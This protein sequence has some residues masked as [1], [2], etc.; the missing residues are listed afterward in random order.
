MSDNTGASSEPARSSR[1]PAARE[2]QVPFRAV[3]L[4]V[5]LLVG[6]LLVGALSVRV[7]GR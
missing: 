6:L 4:F 2:E 7:P 1:R 5:S 3:T